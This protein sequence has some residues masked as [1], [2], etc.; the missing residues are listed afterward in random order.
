MTDADAPPPPPRQPNSFGRVLLVLLGLAAGLALRYGYATQLAGWVA[1]WEADAF[2]RAWEGRPWEALNRLRPPGADWLY[3]RIAEELGGTPSILTLRLASVGVSVA[4]LIAA[5]DLALTMSRSS[6]IQRRSV[7]AAL[8]FVTWIWA[9]HPTLIAASVRPDRVVLLGGWL[10]FTVAGALRIHQEH[11]IVGWLQ[12][13]VGLTASVLT[14]GIIVAFA[15]G[16]GLIWSLLPVPRFAAMARVVSAF[17]LAFG[18]AWFVQRGPLTEPPRPWLPDTAGMHS[19]MALVEAPFTMFDP[20]EIDPDAREN[21]R[22]D[23]LADAVE[24]TPSIEV[25]RDVIDRWVGDFHGP[26]RFEGLPGSW[27][28]PWS[29]LAI[30][31]LEG[32]LRGGVLLFVVA[33]LTS[34]PI[35][36]DSA[37]PRAGAIVAFILFGLLTTLTLTGPFDLAALDMLLV[38]MAGAGMAGTDPSRPGA[39]RTFFL[40][41]GALACTFP[42]IAW[43]ADLPPSHWVLHGHARQGEPAALVA[44]YDYLREVPDDV[45]AL[46]RA[47]SYLMHYETPFVRLPEAALRRAWQQQDLAPDGSL[48]VDLVVRALLENGRIDEARDVATDSVLITNNND[49]SARKMLDHVD[50]V[51]RLQRSRG[52]Q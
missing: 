18:V 22:F 7:L 30:A 21:A 6:T 9:L 41:G 39:R 17:A 49:A 26:L 8:V 19:A 23:M 12:L 10:C 47:T 29:A 42:L 11:F 52:E 20:A 31:L 43:R 45:E 2:L 44:Q 50:H 28:R 51:A 3:H 35:A 5:F 46:Q 40:I 34:T 15:A 14:G 24:N 13:A 48:A 4:A 27:P 33:T 36:S 25:F 1:D 37:W 32:L 16:V 38:G